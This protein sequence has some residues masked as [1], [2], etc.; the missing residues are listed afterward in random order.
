MIRVPQ[1]GEV[2]DQ[3][4]QAVRLRPVW[5]VAPSHG[6]PGNEREP[7]QRHGINLFVYDGL[8]PDSERCRSDQCRD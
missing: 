3:D 2:S 5:I 8:R 4:E 1:S 7:E 6:Q